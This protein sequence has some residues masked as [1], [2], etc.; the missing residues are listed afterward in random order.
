MITVAGYLGRLSPEIVDACWDA[1]LVVASA[2]AFE[3]LATAHGLVPAPSQRIVLGPLTDA[4]DALLVREATDATA[5]ED[6]RRPR[7]AVVLAS[8]DPLL[9]GIVRRLREAGLT[10][11]VLPGVSSVAAAFA[12]VALPWD[13]AQVV[14]AHGFP[15]ESA[16]A[17]CRALPKVAVLTAPGRGVR[18]LARELAGQDRWYVV[19]ER[20]GEPDERVRVVDGTTAAAL[21]DVAEP[22]VVLVLAYPPDDP[23]AFGAPS[24]Y[25]GGDRSFAALAATTTDSTNHSQGARMTSDDTMTPG[26][27]ASTIGQIVGSSPAARRRAEEIDTLLGGT[28]ILEGPA[29]ESLPLAWRECDAIV[30]HLAL[31]ATTRIIAP[32]LADKTADPAVVVV[33][34]GGR[35]AVPLVGGHAGGGNDLARRI[36][37]G[38]GATAVVTTATDSLG[39][40]ALDTLGWAY[41]GDVARVTRAVLDGRPVRL[42]RDYRCPLPPLPGNVVELA[43]TGS[44]SAD[45]RIVVTD[46]LAETVLADAATPTV[47]LHPPALVV[48]I[49][50]NSGTSREHLEDLLRATLAEAGLAVESVAALTTIDLKAGELGLVQ[51]ATALGVPLVD[52]PADRLAAQDVP[53]PSPLVQGHVGSPSVAEASV[54]AH[55]AELVVPKHKSSDATCAVGRIPARGRLTV[56]GL[57]PGSRDLLTPM[58]VTAIQSAAYVVGYGPYVRQ[59]RDLIRP[60]AQVRAS[61]MG[62][63]NERTAFAI[64]R[65]REGASVVVVCSGDPAVYAMAS[66]VL[67]R[68]TDGIDVVVVPGVTAGL[69]ASSLL[70]APL[71]HD[72]ATISLS[73]LHTPW[74]VI[75]RRLVA[76]AQG[77]LVTVLYNPR[78][79]TRR[80]HLPRAL[81][82]F[83]EHR[84]PGTPVALVRDAYRRRQAVTMTTLDAFD[85]EL[86]D[87]NSLVLIGSST[88]RYVTS[89][90]GERRM[91]T[92]RDYTW[93]PDAPAD[94]PATDAE[95]A[96]R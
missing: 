88:T 61:K 10:C 66:P 24:A 21:N 69:A 47:V 7:G 56:V 50:C 75:E 28:R 90:G 85:P 55:G 71:G 43:A 36:A 91:V 26:S 82:I 67:E 6:G 48:G 89:G 3:T 68:G 86:V 70:G 80:H 73:D 8:G 93:M 1:D 95:G 62:T 46:R 41:R 18:E 34:E 31:G 60:G 13:D 52:F 14:S 59:I 17:A 11:R 57:G 84:E 92:P 35:F 64:D 9:Y 12:A 23:R 2:R 54:V 74:D 40:T 94:A 45:A 39:V 81:E 30:S 25:L 27:G 22:N 20:L 58:A 51:L 87:M 44:P 83:G 33:D 32:L 38:L 15:L 79:K 42:V 77:D 63:E 4:I 16:V 72:H 65:A 19:A 53:T 49:G 96:R 37:A 29:A 76:A 5:W 78:S